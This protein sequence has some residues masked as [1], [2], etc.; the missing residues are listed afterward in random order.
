MT[1]TNNSSPVVHTYWSGWKRI[2]HQVTTLT[3]VLFFS[4]YDKNQHLH[5]YATC[6]LTIQE[7]LTMLL[8]KLKPSVQ[9]KK[10][11]QAKYC[12][13]RT[14]FYS[15]WVARACLRKLTSC[16]K[17]FFVLFIKW[18]LLSHGLIKS[19]SVVRSLLQHVLCQF[20]IKSIY[21]CFLE[22]LP[23]TRVLFGAEL[24]WNPNKLMEEWSCRTKLQE[25]S[26]SFD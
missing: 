9:V 4:A 15:Q 12:T 7:G 18:F 1:N 17:G 5:F 16:S 6:T 22:P 8:T 10:A 23:N 14:S 19:K 2:V 25:P 3:E 20:I 24:S 13:E 11:D 26:T 21:K